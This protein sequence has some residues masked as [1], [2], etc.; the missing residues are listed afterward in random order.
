MIRPFNRKEDQNQL[1]NEYE[2]YF[3]NKI[4]KNNEFNKMDMDNKNQKQLI[5]STLKTCTFEK[6]ARAYTEESFFTYKL[7]YLLGRNQPEKCKYY[8]SFFLTKKPQID[9]KLYGD[10][11]HKC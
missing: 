3:E 10:I 1:I 9:L 6:L 5:K 2:D 11:C 7:N 8:L 4:D